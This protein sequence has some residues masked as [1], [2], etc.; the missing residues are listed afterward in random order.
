MP[1]MRGS[2]RRCACTVAHGVALK[3]TFALFANLAPVRN[4]N[5][6]LQLPRTADGELS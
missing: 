4:A 6:E 3:V 2:S 5:S 1:S